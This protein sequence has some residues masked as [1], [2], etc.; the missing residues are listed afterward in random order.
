MG[1]F[2]GEH[3]GAGS[4]PRRCGR[5]PS[6]AR[7]AHAGRAGLQPHVQHKG[8]PHAAHDASTSAAQPHENSTSPTIHEIAAAGESGSSGPLPSADRIQRSFGRQM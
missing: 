3:P 5:S 8:A 1:G 2:E 4:A 7:Q 6:I